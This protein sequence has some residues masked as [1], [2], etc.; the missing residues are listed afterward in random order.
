MVSMINAPLQ[1]KAMISLR[2]ILLKCA[3]ILSLFI[4]ETHCMNCRILSIHTV[5]ALM[6]NRIKTSRP[7]CTKEKQNNEQM[8]EET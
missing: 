6:M 3:Y 7:M 8:H 5:L 4:G 2:M 1:Q